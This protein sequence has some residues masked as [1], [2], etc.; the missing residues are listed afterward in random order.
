METLSS[1]VRNWDKP[2]CSNC[3][4]VTGILMDYC[5]KLDEDVAWFVANNRSPKKCPRRN[6]SQ[7]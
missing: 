4:Y 6:N 7:K 2:K 3:P 1:I 5:S